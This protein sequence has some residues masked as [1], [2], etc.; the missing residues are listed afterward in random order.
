MRRGGSAV[1]RNSRFYGQDVAATKTLSDPGDFTTL[2]K[3]TPGEF[4]ECVAGKRVDPVAASPQK[5]WADAT[6]CL[7]DGRD[8][9]ITQDDLA[10]V[11]VI[12]SELAVQ[13]QTQAS[14]QAQI[15]TPA[16]LACR[17]VL[18]N[19]A[20]ALVD[21]FKACSGLDAEALV[22]VIGADDAILTNLQIKLS[23]LVR[24]LESGCVA[25]EGSS[26]ASS[27]DVV[28][29]KSAECEAQMKA[30]WRGV[31]GSELLDADLEFVRLLVKL[32][33]QGALPQLLSDVKA[34]VSS[35]QC[36]VNKVWL[37]AAFAIS[38]AF[39]MAMIALNLY[40][41]A[42]GG[43]LVFTLLYNISVL[44][45]RKGVLYLVYEIVFKGDKLLTALY[46]ASVASLVLTNLLAFAYVTKPTVVDLT[47]MVASRAVTLIVMTLSFAYTVSRTGDE[48]A[49]VATLAVVKI[50]RNPD[51]VE[52][53]DR[54]SR[55]GFL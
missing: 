35:G 55:T 45:S 37:V 27:R 21:T 6:E 50:L 48:K 42:A 32:W 30:V 28:V 38:A 12:L 43:L 17:S 20:S 24:L 22:T 4:A 26:P 31:T 34:V 46:I 44:T 2:C 7:G 40:G 54:A 13:A 10:D 36:R 18:R 53:I 11:P 9:V 47:L 52:A 1:D 41:Y 29:S 49:C 39:L 14:S 15:E 33:N 19:E 5:F 16:M 25:V 3:M 23:G 51:L 8:L